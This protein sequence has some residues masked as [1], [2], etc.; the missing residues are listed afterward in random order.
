MKAINCPDHSDAVTSS[1]E[2]FECQ[3][4]SN[5]EAKLSLNGVDKVFL[6]FFQMGESTRL[7]AEDS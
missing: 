2:D 1:E 5:A 6:L 3:S 4:T 7:L